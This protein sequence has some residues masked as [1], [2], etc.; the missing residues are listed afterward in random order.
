MRHFVVRGRFFPF[1][2]VRLVNEVGGWLQAWE[3]SIGNKIKVLPIST[4][5]P[6][7]VLEFRDLSQGQPNASVP[8]C[9]IQRNTIDGK[10][11]VGNS[12]D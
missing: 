8:R 3:A 4:I 10:L 6:A 11:D 1:R 12:L 2:N 7:L 5:V 9:Q